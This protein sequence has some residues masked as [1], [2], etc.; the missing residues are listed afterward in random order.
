[1]EYKSQ[2][3]PEMGL[4]HA[5]DQHPARRP[6]SHVSRILLRPNTEFRGARLADVI[7]KEIIPRL[8]L[9][10]HDINSKL[11]SEESPQATDI[12]A[13]GELVMSPDIAQAS[14]Y[15]QEMRTKGHSVNNL[16]VHFLEP[17]ARYLGELWEQ[18]RVDF[19]DVTIGVGHLQELLSTVGSKDDAPIRDA[20]FRA[21]LITTPGE[22]HMFGVDMVA[23]FMRSAGWDVA[24]EPC[25]SAKESAN[26]ASLSW[27]GVVGLTLSHDS[28]LEAAAR[29]IQAV[30]RASA[31][32]F[33]SIMVGGP[34]FTKDPELAIQIGADAVAVDAQT[35]V[36]LAKKLLLMQPAD[37]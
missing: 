23:Q 7:A 25:Q 32:A 19:L 2:L 26:S 36:I 14:A 33:V 18:D 35:A 16:L 29:I 22:K 28:G 27:F 4:F 3:A 6:L 9:H 20:H 17:T 15:F 24:V 8:E 10:H 1:M 21:L 12:A 34:V 30:K 31:N 5:P 11:S 37:S 13:L